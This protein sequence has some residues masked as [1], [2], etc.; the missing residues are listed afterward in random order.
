MAG[1]LQGKAAR[2]GNGVR[3]EHDAEVAFERF[4]VAL[5]IDVTQEALVDTPRRVVSA[6]RE[7]LTPRPFELTTFANDEAYDE[8]V[9]VRS[10]PFTSLCEHHLLPFCGTAH[11]A[12]LP[13]SRILGLSKVARV[14]ELHACRLQVQERMT[15]QIATWLWENLNPKG[16]GVVVSAE[17]T[18]MTLRGVKAPGALTV[19]SA[20]RGA[21]RDDPDTRREF[22]G[23]IGSANG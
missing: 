16:V 10:I 14:V 12:Y 13:G 5:G 18:C 19:T 20:L 21:F 8:M 23:L 4:M 3:A 15:A 22:L 7:F 17:H 11:V 6:F 9:L 1:V 2:T